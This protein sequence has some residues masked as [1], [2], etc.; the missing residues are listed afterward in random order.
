MKIDLL[1]ETSFRA[2]KRTHKK[3]KDDDSCY[4]IVVRMAIVRYYCEVADI[5][6]CNIVSIAFI[7]LTLRPMTI[8]PVKI[9]Q[10]VNHEMLEE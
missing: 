10:Y 7:L 1:L 6:N 8:C 5:K 4:D 3:V 2:S 9:A